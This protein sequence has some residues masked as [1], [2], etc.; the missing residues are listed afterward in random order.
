MRQTIAVITARKPIVFIMLVVIFLIS[1][2]SPRIYAQVSGATLSGTV[3]DP[4]GS[5]IAGAQVSIKNVATGV[6]TGATTNSEG[7]YSASNLLPG[8]YDV[9]ASASGFST[10]IQSGVALTVGAQQVLMFSLRVGEVSQ[11]VNVTGE[12]PSVELASS[13]ISGNID[14][15]TV[16]E[17]PLNGR[18][19][20]LL[21]ILDPSVHTISTQ[22]AV[23][24]NVSRGHRGFGNQL[25][26]AGTRP[27][28]NN[29]RID[30][31]SV[32]D[33]SG[34]GP[35]SVAGS[36]L[37]VDAI[38]Q[39][40]VITANYSAD[41]GR[42]AGGVVNAIT[43]SGSNQLHGVAYGFLRGKALD[44]RN[45][46]DTTNV[47]FHRYQYGG[48]V[49][50][51]IKKDKT[52]FFADYEAFRQGL[53]VT[54]VDKVPSQDARNGILH[55]ANGTTTTVTVDP[56]AAQ[57]L[58]FWPIS[59]GALLGT[60]NTQIYNTSFNN[61]AHDNFVTTRIDHTF[62]NKDSAS[63]TYLF[64]TSFYDSPDSL[65]TSIFGNQ[66]SRQ[67]AALEE[68]HIF[69]QSITN[70]AR[71]GYSR[72]VGI[73][74]EPAG[75]I[76]PLA[77]QAGI[78]AFPGRDAS[79]VSITGVTGF[80]G[81]V[82]AL[83]APFHYWNSFQVYDDAFLIKGNHSI[84]FGFSFERIQHNSNFSNRPNGNF[85][86]SSLQNFLTNIP[87]Q[88]SGSITGFQSFRLRQSI[89][90]VYVQD[91]WRVRPNLTLNLGLRY[92]MATV[93]TE[94]NN[95]LVNLETLT[96]ATP[97][98][99]SPLFQ[100]PTYRN[101]EPRVGFS[102]DPFHNGKTAV[103]GAFGIF[104][105]LPLTD[106]IFA[107]VIM[108]APYAELITAPSLPAGSFPHPA[109]LAA[110][111]SNPATLQ[112]MWIE[113]NPKR[114]Y[115]MIYNLNIEQ[116][117][118]TSMTASI[119]YVGSHTVHAYNREDDMNT[120]LPTQTPYGLLFPFPA[121]SGTRLNPNIGDIRGSYWGGS[122]LYDA[123]EAKFTKKLSHG[124]QGQ[125]A[126]TWEK[127]IDTG[128]ATVLGDPFTNS[129]ASPWNFWPGRRG[130]SD[131]NISH[132]F[133]LNYIW[134]VPTPKN[135]TGAESHVL[136]GWEVGGI[137][138]AQTGVPFTPLISGNP[139][140]LNSNDLWAYPDLVNSPGCSSPVN[141]GN[142][143]NYI[144]LNCFALPAL[145]TGAPASLQAQCTPFSS[146]PG[147]C[148][149]LLGN[150]T[151]NSV[152]GPGLVNLDFSL[153]KNNYIKQV[154]E[155][156][157]IQLRFEFFNIFNHPN[158]Q[159]PIDNDA[160]FDTNGNPVAGAGAVDTTATTSRQIQFGMRVIW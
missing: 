86:F 132:R 41:Y 116:Q 102:W 63:G 113:P 67:L 28:T 64:D 42:T 38:S 96:A 92:E 83:S 133:V 100:N 37:G 79:G 87:L 23:G 2:F 80:S 45:F 120:V 119:G 29:Y 95:K 18:D 24:A 144:K 57:Y 139:L 46:F 125:A 128:S 49:G 158:F 148:S 70:S 35:G 89:P 8:N 138:L 61:P 90:G 152:I 52:F 135:W 34:G 126:Y 153:F 54:V 22:F 109:G 75:V 50:G 15:T 5:A 62:S 85:S 97:T 136:G 4:S 111:A 137:F 157:N 149:N 121:G 43:S 16:V 141:P 156:F 146:T 81:G 143:S 14:S 108:S 118:T 117:I 104:D 65:S 84:K 69:S 7:F 72:V 147:T 114:N 53:G 124:I 88:F 73:A 82:G 11:T 94:V 105:V 145:P 93:P 19:W 77:A 76:D 17:L 127:G 112:S 31:I 48:S 3:R 26:V 12:A 151:R 40:T 27:Q 110:L 10:E 68:T 39:F 131:Y 1:I 140:G 32:M 107:Q 130:L 30:G 150:L 101:F 134:D 98:L 74:D 71:F 33:Y 159:A 123:L 51:P 44:A 20:T 122:A 58:Q 21:A 103:R 78:G 154:S 106:E 129:I 36:A 160:L 155:N 6:S 66:S 99:G 55:N 56:A 47:P 25:S 9:S 60:G 115:V 13:E 142:P 59:S 91:D